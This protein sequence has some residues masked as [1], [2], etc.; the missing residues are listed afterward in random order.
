MRIDLICV[1]KLKEDYWRAACAEYGKRLS[2]YVK[3]QV[4]ETP[5]LPIPDRASPAQQ[6]AIRRQEGA[7]MLERLPQG[8]RA[9]ALDGQGEMLTSEQLSARIGAWQMDGRSVALLIGGSLGLHEDVLARCEMRISMGRMTFPHQLA[10]VMALEQ[11]YR[12]Y[13]IL[14]GERYHK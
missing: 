2:R 1:G 4:V 3:L 10:R 7:R 6:D 11:L 5:D 12:G 9:V 14:R 8:A 13:R